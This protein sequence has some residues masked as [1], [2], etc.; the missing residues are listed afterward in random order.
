[1]THTSMWE[2]VKCLRAEQWATFLC[3]C[4]NACIL[5]LNAC[6]LRLTKTL[7]CGTWSTCDHGLNHKYMCMWWSTGVGDKTAFIFIEGGEGN[8]KRLSNLR[9]ES[10]RPINQP[11]MK[12]SF[13]TGRRQKE[14]CAGPRACSTTLHPLPAPA[15]IFMGREEDSVVWE[16]EKLNSIFQLQLAAYGP[17]CFY[18]AMQIKQMTPCQSVS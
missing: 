2:D 14:N 18:L 3:S 10:Q 8:P 4:L 17:R 11:V 13:P 9:G 12:V 16:E 15:G 6:A 5:G 1:M 7:V